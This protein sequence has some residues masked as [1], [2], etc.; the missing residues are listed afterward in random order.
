MKT[1][2]DEIVN[3]A[4][5]FEAEDPELEALLGETDQE[6]VGTISPPDYLKW[7]QRSLNRRYGLSI[8][9]NGSDSSAYRD[10][11]RRFNREY[12]GRVSADV[13][14]ETQNNLIFVNEAPGPYLAWVVQALNAA[15]FGPIPATNAY[16]PA[17]LKALKNFQAS[18]KPALK[19]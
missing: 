8:P 14:E 9:T 13:D 17:I 4:L 5:S 6:S 7:V 12:S 16:T 19:V 10:A 18:R 15:G 11:V 2:F 3:E 1:L